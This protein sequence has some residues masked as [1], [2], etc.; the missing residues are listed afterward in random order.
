[1]WRRGRDRVKGPRG[2]HRIVSGLIA[3]SGGCEATMSMYKQRQSISQ[4]IQR[5]EL[6]S[7]RRHAQ[8]SP[9]LLDLVLGVVEP[10]TERVAL[11]PRSV[12][13][14]PRSVALI[15]RLVDLVPEVSETTLVITAPAAPTLVMHKAI[16]LRLDSGMVDLGSGRGEVLIRVALLIRIVK[17]K[18]GESVRGVFH[19]TALA[20]TLVMQAIGLR[21]DSGMVDLGSGRG[22]VLI[23]VDGLELVLGAPRGRP[24]DEEGPED[25]HATSDDLKPC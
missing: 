13:L 11:G 18:V 21:L 10:V 22:E 7:G 4:A 6:K 12:A 25:E 8:G 2:W 20:T 14:I 15:P 23:R 24:K 17:A 3:G 16:G 19:T 5:H 1:M 9:R